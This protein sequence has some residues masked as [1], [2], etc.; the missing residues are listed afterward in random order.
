MSSDATALVVSPEP[1]VVQQLGDVLR[2]DFR[3]LGATT[4]PQ[5]LALLSTQVVHVVLS[6]HPLPG[7]SGVDFLRQIRRVAPGALRFLF[8]S[9]P[10]A[11]ASLQAASAGSLF[12]YVSRPWDDDEVLPLLRAA[13]G[14][15]E[16]KH[17][18]P[19]AG[20]PG[21]QPGSEP[22]MA[23]PRPGTQLGQYH[24]IE[25][26]GQGG[27]GTVYRAKHL[28]LKR[29]VALKVLRPEHTRDPQ[30]VARF[31]REMRAAGK[32]AHPNI[33]QASDARKV[34]GLHFLVMEF[35]PGIDLARLV[36]R[37]GSLP[38]PAACEIARQA[39][40][41]L[42]HAH[43]HGMVH[44]DVK[45]A[46]LIVTPSGQVKLLDLGLALLRDDLS[47]AEEPPEEYLVGTADYLAPEQVHGGSTLDGRTDLYSL[48]CTLYELVTGRPPFARFASVSAKLRAHLEAPV[49][50]V[51]RARRDVPRGLAVVLGQL[52][53]K[54]P[55]GRF[56]TAAECTAALE[57][58][59]A[60]ADLA[61]LLQAAEQGISSVPP[62]RAD[63]ALTED[64]CR[65]E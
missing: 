5:A 47:L 34:K 21:R 4:V 13:A 8:A 50:A 35:V 43:T 23:E 33:V 32:L 40:L 28:L 65:E 2:R 44:R 10:E 55:R 30:A 9:N 46:N 63:P 27:M 6:D 20:L 17:G 61:G 39:A 51:R 38:V 29:M 26:L 24:V 12:R 15:A 19:P 45:P 54:V 58:F 18:G 59:A 48:G 53:A 7:M 22:R 14:L 64:F 16:A 56:K 60:A 31:R 57:P 42:Q 3:V 52:L 41:G 11:A 37:L 62:G 49:P 36:A 1:S 25:R